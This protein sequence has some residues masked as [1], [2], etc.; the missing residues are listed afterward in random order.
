[1]EALN[2]ADVRKVLKVG[3]TVADIKE[4]LNAGMETVGIIE[5]SSIMGLTQD[6]YEALPETERE[7]STSKSFPHIRMPVLPTLS[8]TF[9][10]S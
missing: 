2:L 3:D 10:L 6:E 5:G 7:K 1:M 8:E 4:G 9:A